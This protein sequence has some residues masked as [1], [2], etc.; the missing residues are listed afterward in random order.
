MNACGVMGVV[1]SR[2]HVETRAC[3]I[4]PRRACTGL[5]ATATQ[6]HTTFV[7]EINHE[8]SYSILGKTIRLSHQSRPKH[9]PSGTAGQRHRSSAP[10]SQAMAEVCLLAN[11]TITLCLLPVIARHSRIRSRGSHTFPSTVPAE[12]MNHAQML[13]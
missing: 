2:S 1:G 11:F 9:A 7:T 13:L 6:W 8:T 4:L 5:A 3:S 10:T 12:P